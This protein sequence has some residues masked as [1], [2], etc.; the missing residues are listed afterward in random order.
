MSGE[1][2][3]TRLAGFLPNKP[4]G[5]DEMEHF[6]GLIGGKPSRSKALVLRNNRIRSR[7]Y[8][9]DQQGRATHSNAEMVAHAIQ[10]LFDGKYHAAQVDLLAL[11]TTSPDQLIPSHAAMVH[12]V[13]GGAPIE[14]NSPSG[15]CCSGMQ[16]FRY[17]FLAVRSGDKQKAVCGGSERASRLMHSTNF[18]KECEQLAALES[19]PFLAF[20]KDFLR[21]MLSDGAAVA[22]M[23]P[24]PCKGTISLQVNWVDYTS[25]ANETQPCMYQGADKN[26]DGGFIGWSDFSTDERVSRSVFA[27]KQDVRLLGDNIARLGA[28]SLHQS[29]LKHNLSPDEIDFFLPHLSSEFFRAPIDQEMKRVGC[30]IPQEKW[31]TNLTSVGNVGSASIYLMLDELVASGKLKNGQKIL[32]VVPESARFSYSFAQLTVVGN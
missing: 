13:L 3:I 9:I 31:F 23:E 2:Y 16:A 11:G 12:G 8:A 14:I 5:N 25:F 28:I 20:E 6:L 30:G 29:L 10:K 19:N 27:I 22:L 32:L 26:P 21:W 24:Q 17:A 18:D 7:Y 1:A 4:V 15:A